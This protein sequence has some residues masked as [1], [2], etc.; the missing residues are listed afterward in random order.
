MQKHK[1]SHAR[2]FPPEI[3][4]TRAFPYIPDLMRIRKRQII[5]YQQQQQE[6]KHQPR[7]GKRGYITTMPAVGF[8]VYSLFTGKF[9]SFQ[10]DLL[11]QQQLFPRAA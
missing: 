6:Q 9:F 2:D 4:T 3:A 1:P 5:T 7:N 11:L 10:N 8:A